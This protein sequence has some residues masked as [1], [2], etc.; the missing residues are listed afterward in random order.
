MNED[1]DEGTDRWTFRESVNTQHVFDFL[2]CVVDIIDAVNDLKDTDQGNAGL[3]S[4]LSARR[5]SIPLRKLLLDGNGYLFKSCFTDPNFH[6]LKR[7]SPNERPITFVQK[8]KDLPMVIKFADG[9]ETTIEVP[10]YEQRTTIH[11][12]Y[13]M[14]HAGDRDFL[15]EMPFD[16][17]A[18]P[19]KFKAWMNMK[20][21]QIDD[22]MFTAKDLLREIVNNEG[23]HIGDR[24]KFT[25]PDTSSLTMDNQKNKRYK[26]VH[27][28]KFGG[29]SYAQNFTLCTGLYIAHRSKTLIDTLPLDKNG[30]AVANI[31]KKIE[32]GPRELHGRGAM[33]NQTYH[34]LVL[35]SDRK[36]RS[37]SIGDY[38]ILLQIP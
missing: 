2:L 15:I 7:P 1:K 13:G 21:L 37:E 28:V 29:L 19:I 27:A 22:M 17:A 5:I 35:D 9:K 12:L 14:R 11:P 31:C 16:Y 30:K 23:A 32:G 38:S 8:F 10:E 6:P 18:R 3:K 20:I 26:A 36:L 25:F 4:I 24:V 34:G 33:E